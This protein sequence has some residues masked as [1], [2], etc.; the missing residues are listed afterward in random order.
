[1]NIFDKDR[2][3]ISDLEEHK[4]ELKQDLIAKYNHV[5]KLMVDELNEKIEALNAL[6]PNDQK[7]LIEYYDDIDDFDDVDL[8]HEEFVHGTSY[9]L[10]ENHKDIVDVL[11]TLEEEGIDEIFS[12][13]GVRDYIKDLE[14]SSLRD[15]SS[16]IA[17][18]IDW[19]GVIDDCMNDYSTIDIEGEAFYYV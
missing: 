16:A 17:N 12:E 7:P 4:D 15:V 10:V 19:E 9:Q 13:D 1:M 8:T 2:I 11:K 6:S 18:N 5:K 14:E 3:T